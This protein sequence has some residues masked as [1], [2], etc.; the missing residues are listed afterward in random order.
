MGLAN[1]LIDAASKK[2]NSPADN[3]IDDINR[4]SDTID[5][6]P[7]SMELPGDIQQKINDLTEKS[8]KLEKDIEDVDNMRSTAEKVKDRVSAGIKTAKAVISSNSILSAGPNAFAA[9]IVQAQQII[10]EKLEDEM[11]DLGIMIEVLKGDIDIS[12]NRLQKAIGKLNQSVKRNREE[13]AAV[14]RRKAENG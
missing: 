14:K 10:K 9:G 8:E 1:K 2:I 12:I 6:M 5:N 11:D 3:M 7:P 13:S 4:L